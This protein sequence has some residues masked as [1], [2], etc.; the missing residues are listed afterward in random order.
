MTRFWL[1]M[2]LLA[3]GVAACESRPD[4]PDHAPPPERPPA[5]P[6]PG[7]ATQSSAPAQSAMALPPPTGAAASPAA[8]DWEGAFTAAK[9]TVHVPEGVKDPSR[10]KDDGK[11]GVGPGKVSL[12]VSSDGE[13]NGSW[14]GSLGKDSLR[15]RVEVE[16]G[17]TMLRATAMPDD[18]TAREAMSGILV[19]EL[20]GDAFHAEIHVSAGDA[21]TVR[22]ATFDLKRR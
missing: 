17:R 10:E 11:T 6:T 8:G 19:G 16:G 18:P 4:P 2:A 12:T 14:T 1:S 13:V 5:A 9:G 3:V 15:G 22:E 20:K 21:V 7:G